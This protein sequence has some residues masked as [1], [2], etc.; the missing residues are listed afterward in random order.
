VKELEQISRALDATP[1]VMALVFQDPIATH[2]ADT[3]RK[4]MTA[5]QVLRCAKHPEAAP[6]A[7]LRRTGLSSR[8]LRHLPELF[9]A[10][11]GA[12]PLE[13]HPP[14]D[15]QGDPGRDVGRAL[16]VQISTN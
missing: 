14:E 6:G 8:G 12:V 9:P 11:D 7:D 4:E 16:S 1:R 15:H 5:E 3:G 13:V 2:R 10:G